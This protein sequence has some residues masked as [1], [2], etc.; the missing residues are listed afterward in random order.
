MRENFLFNGKIIG[1]IE[2]NTFYSVR[3]IKH[4]FYKIGGFG[5]SIRILAELQNRGIENFC[6]IYKMNLFQVKKYL[7]NV[8]DF[9]N[10]GEKFID[11]SN[12]FQDPQL[13]LPLQFWNK[14]H[15]VEIQA[16]LGK[17]YK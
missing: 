15:E 1:H 9:Y 14:K 3:N 7:C 8:V 2:E 11:D 4:Y 13:I 5:C 17:V 10:H 16:D 6:V 12:G